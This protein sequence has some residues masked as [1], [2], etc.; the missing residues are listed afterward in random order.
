MLLVLSLLVLKQ[1]EF[2]ILTTRSLNNWIYKQQTL[3]ELEEEMRVLQAR[4][5]SL[6]SACWTFVSQPSD[7]YARLKNG[8]GCYFVKNQQ[9]YRYFLEDLGSFPC[10]RMVQNQQVYS[11]RHR[12]I[13][14]V[15]LGKT[16]EKNREEKDFL[17]RESKFLQVHFAEKIALESCK[18]D[19]VKKIPSGWLS[20]LFY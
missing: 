1:L 9:E 7:L 12:R 18:I 17:I 15:Y 11:T 6:P 2:A 13:S 4:I 16:G 14:L 3:K 10:L 19:E 20:W 8:Q 5:N